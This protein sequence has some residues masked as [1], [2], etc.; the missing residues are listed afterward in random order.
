[1]KT[2]LLKKVRKRFAIYQVYDSVNGN[3]VELWDSHFPFGF[4]KREIQTDDVK[5]G[6]EM[7]KTNILYI[8][9]EEYGYLKIKKRKKLWP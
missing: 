9:R 5:F 4:A 7:M 2:K 1:M 8:L 6:I 3:S